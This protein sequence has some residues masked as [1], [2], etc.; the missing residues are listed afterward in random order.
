[1]GS[2]VIDRSSRRIASWDARLLQEGQVVFRQDIGELWGVVLL[3]GGAMAT[4]FVISVVYGAGQ[5]MDDAGAVFG[6]VALFLAVIFIPFAILV[7]RYQGKTLVVKTE[8][9]QVEN[10]DLVPWSGLERAE[11]RKVGHN[12]TVVLRIRPQFFGPEY[13]RKPWYSRLNMVLTFR[14]MHGPYIILSHAMKA[15]HEEFARWVN[16]RITDPPGPPNP[17]AHA[18][19]WY[20]KEL[21]RIK[22]ASS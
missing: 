11:I 2:T 15:D 7:L 6:W 18:P 1:M 3:A 22:A 16:M 14:Y 5:G 10:G 12:R 8:G 20:A 21:E 9:I 17:R 13:R 4:G 19:V